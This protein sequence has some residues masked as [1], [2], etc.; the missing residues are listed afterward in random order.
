MDEDLR[1]LRRDEEAKFTWRTCVRCKVSQPPS[2]IRLER[3]SFVCVGC[4]AGDEV[5]WLGSG[6]VALTVPP[7]VAASVGQ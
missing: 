5:G 3:G 1:A 7:A 4:L 2:A 6:V